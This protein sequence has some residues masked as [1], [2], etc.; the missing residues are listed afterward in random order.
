MV[1]STAKAEIR[2]QLN[3]IF[4]T[5]KLLTAALDI[6]NAS[7]RD[8][9]AATAESVFEQSAVLSQCV[10]EFLGEETCSSAADI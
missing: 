6:D 10:K 2:S 3:L 4:A 7:A 8:A 5:M 1:Q 9:V